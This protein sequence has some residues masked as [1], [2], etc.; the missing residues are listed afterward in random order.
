[1]V[2]LQPIDA[3]I[4]ALTEHGCQNITID[5]DWISCSVLPFETGGS[6]DIYQGKLSGGSKIAIKTLRMHSSGNNALKVLYFLM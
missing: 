3:V 2:S 1:M 6:A 4:S 5:L